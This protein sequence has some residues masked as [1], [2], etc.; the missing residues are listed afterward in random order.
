MMSGKMAP[1][2][3]DFLNFQSVLWAVTVLTAIPCGS[4]VLKGVMHALRQAASFA[5]TIPGAS[6]LVMLSCFQTCALDSG[7]QAV[8]V[9]HLLW[10]VTSPTMLVTLTEMAIVMLMDMTAL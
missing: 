10:F 3:L 4:M 2:M 6:L 1:V 7:K 5:D 9:P 8:T